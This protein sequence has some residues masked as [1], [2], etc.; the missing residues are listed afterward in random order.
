MEVVQ[1]PH[2][3]KPNFFIFYFVSTLAIGGGRTTPVTLG[4]DSATPK[5]KTSFFFFFFF[6]FHF[7]PYWW[8]NHPQAKWG[9]F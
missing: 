9:W 6:F 7:G 2:G 3:E 1:P 8:L 4:S 5:A